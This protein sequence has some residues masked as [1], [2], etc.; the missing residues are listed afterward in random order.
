MLGLISPQ[1]AH[2]GAVLDLIRSPAHLW[3]DYGLRSLS[4]EHELFG[5]DENYWRGNIWIQMNYM[6]L[7]SLFKVDLLFVL[8]GRVDESQIYMVEPG[9][10][11]WKAREVY[12]D[13]RRNIV[14]NVFKEYQ[15]TGYVWEQYDATT[16]EG[17]RRSDRISVKHAKHLT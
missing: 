8:R 12:T 7:S 2:L 5:K 16:G 10:N 3:S 17:R 13:L 9:P 11:Q 15:R 1:S 6:V 4:P 14:E